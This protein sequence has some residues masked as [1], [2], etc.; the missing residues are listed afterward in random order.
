MP[1]PKPT[2]L[3]RKIAAELNGRRP[4]FR[5]YFDTDGDVTHAIYG[6]EAFGPDT[7]FTWQFRTYSERGVPG[8]PTHHWTA[9]EVQYT[10]TPPTDADP[11]EEYVN[12]QARTRTGGSR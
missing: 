11:G 8:A 2:K 9:G 1:Q 5:V 7:G 6:P 10:L 3:A 4:G 12:Y